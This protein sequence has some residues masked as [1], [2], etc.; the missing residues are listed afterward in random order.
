M[1]SLRA[2][3]FATKSDME[4]AEDRWE[5]EV[6]TQHYVCPGR[7]RAEK[8]TDWTPICCVCICCGGHLSEVAMLHYGQ[9]IRKQRERVLY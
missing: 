9:V 6:W 1:D 8:F 7:F 4:T 5:N 3:L 2:T